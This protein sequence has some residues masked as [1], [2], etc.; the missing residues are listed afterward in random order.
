MAFG[1]GGNDLPM[2]RDA[3]VGVAMGNACDELKSVADYITSSVD[4]DG[5]SRALE[6]FGLI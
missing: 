1:D 4:E 3:A 5:V 2:V 6:H